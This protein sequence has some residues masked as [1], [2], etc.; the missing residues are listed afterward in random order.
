[1]A[2][3]RIVRD[4]RAYLPVSREP[5]RDYSRLEGTAFRRTGVAGLTAIVV[6]AGA[7]GTRC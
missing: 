3:S 4:V 7:L 6:G 5:V 2:Q 1:M